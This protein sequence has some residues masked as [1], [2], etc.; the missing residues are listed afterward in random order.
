MAAP[1]RR[2]G[3]LA[4]QLRH[5]LPPSSAHCAHAA[6]DTAAAPPPQ[7]LR[8]DVLAAFDRERWERDG[9]WVWE[10]VLTTEGR[11]R[12]AASMAGLQEIH[13][14]MIRHTD[15]DGIDWEGRGLPPPLEGATTIEFREA[16][17]VGG[18]KSAGTNR[19]LPQQSRDYMDTHG[20]CELA[21]P[22]GVPCPG[23]M[24]DWCPAAFDPLVRS[25]ALLEE[26]GF[27]EMQELLFGRSDL[28]LDHQV[29]LNRK[30]GDSGASWHAHDRG[31]AG[32]E[33]EGGLRTPNP[34]FL[35]EQV[36]RTLI[37]PEGVT[38]ESGGQ[39]SLIPGSHHYRDCYN[40]AFGTQ[41]AGDH[42]GL[43]SGWLDGK[44]HARTGRP[45]AIESFDLPPGSMVSFVHHML[46]HVGERHSGP[47]GVRWGLLLTYRN[48]DTAY[49]SQHEPRKFLAGV[50]Q[51]WAERELAAGRLSA[52]AQRVLGRVAN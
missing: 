51:H 35:E 16:N 23:F 18:A 43:S 22:D 24:P 25:F 8:P 27:R 1:R 47:W 13:D 19:L 52:G 28:I 6:A 36:V 3:A 40:R 49:A 17:C 7:L 5:S 42:A 4:T 45:L 33:V 14:H 32:V 50:P 10:G 9:L 20:L 21:T 37:F 2:L 30:P 31:M 44:V 39:V 34:T 29:M 38:A 48:A 15:W 26:P 46:H 12:M 41:G 11:E